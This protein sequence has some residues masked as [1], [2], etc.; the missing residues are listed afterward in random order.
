ME[1]KHIVTLLIFSEFVS[2]L[3]NVIFAILKKTKNST[4][5]MQFD[6]PSKQLKMQ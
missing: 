6:K 3:V 4:K 5:Q 1:Y 2:F